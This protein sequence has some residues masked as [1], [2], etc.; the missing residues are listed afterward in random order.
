MLRVFDN[1]L[2]GTTFGSKEVTGDWRKFHSGE[3]HDLYSFPS[4]VW[5]VKSSSMGWAG[6]VARNE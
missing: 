2:S 5:V 1:R 3:L 6:H 4:T